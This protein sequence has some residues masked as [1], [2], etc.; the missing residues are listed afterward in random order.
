MDDPHPGALAQKRCSRHP[1]REAAA[2]CPECHGFFCRECITEH[3][4]RVICAN[5]LAR[6]GAARTNAPKRKR[7]KYLWHATQCIVG[8]MFAWLYF[9]SWSRILVAIP[10]NFHEGS[11]W[12]VLS[13]HE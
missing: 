8:V 4:S 9:Y 2:R 3:D 5:C 6:L 7:W 10:E 1:M 12:S 11:A 13:N